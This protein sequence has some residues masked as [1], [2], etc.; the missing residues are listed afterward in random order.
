MT[1][2]VHN[3]TSRSSRPLSLERLIEKGLEHGQMHSTSIR[4]SL[5]SCCSEMPCMPWTLWKKLWGVQQL[6][7]VLTL[8]LLHVAKH[9]EERE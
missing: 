1:N 8:V 2:D 5:S 7:V 3:P 9:W 4:P 6:R